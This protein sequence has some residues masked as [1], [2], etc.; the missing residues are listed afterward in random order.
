MSIPCTLIQV[1]NVA[2]RYVNGKSQLS[3][4]VGVVGYVGGSVV[5]DQTARNPVR[6][7]Q[8]SDMNVTVS[9]LVLLMKLQGWEIDPQCFEKLSSSTQSYLHVLSSSISK[10]RK[11]IFILCPSSTESVQVYTNTINI[12]CRISINS[13]YLILIERIVQ[14]IVC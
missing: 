11:V 3:Q 7:S 13:F 2:S 14:G 4:P 1:S 6:V 10:C 9:V 12:K 8:S 5:A